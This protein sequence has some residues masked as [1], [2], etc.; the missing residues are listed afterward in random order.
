MSRIGNFTQPDN[1]PAYF[2]EFLELLDKQAEVSNIRKEAAKRL[3]LFAGDQVFAIGCGMGGACF[4]RAAIPGPKGLAVCVD[5][6]SAMIE[7]ATRRCGTPQ[8]MEFR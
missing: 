4:P 7:V 2:I 3:D 8:G 1:S 6:S 5:I